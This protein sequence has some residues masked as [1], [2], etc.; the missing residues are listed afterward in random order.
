MPQKQHAQVQPILAGPR[1]TAKMTAAQP[2][3][4]TAPTNQDPWW[5]YLQRNSQT[6]PT[7]PATQGPMEQ[8][9][10]QQDAKVQELES[11]IE[12]LQNT[13]AQQTGQIK[14]VHDDLA[15]TE[16]KLIHTMHQTMMESSR[17]WQSPS[18]KLWP[19][20]Q[21]NLRA[22]SWTSRRL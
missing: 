9:F 5:N 15:Q 22:I 7:A 8:R 14:K 12:A 2:T 21:S 1:S 6:T 11:K 20:N 19:S 13:Q 4:Q 10:A 18:V 17:N 3:A 16:K